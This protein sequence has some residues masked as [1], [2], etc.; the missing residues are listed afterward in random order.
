[1]KRVLVQGNAGL[2][3]NKMT[4]PNIVTNDWVQNGSVDYKVR[5]H[6][7]TPDNTIEI[8][9]TPTLIWT[10][11]GD[12][13]YVLQ[14]AIPT[15]DDLDSILLLNFNG[16]DN[17]LNTYDGSLNYH[18]ITSDGTCRL[19]T[20]QK[21]F[22][23]SS[24][25]FA[26]DG[27]FIVDNY[28]YQTDFG[29]LTGDF[30]WDF[31]IYKTNAS[32]TGANAVILGFRSGAGITSSIIVD[33]AIVVSI[34]DVN[35]YNSGYINLVP[36]GQWSHIVVVRVSGILYVF[37]NELQL[38]SVA[39]V[40]SL[41]ASYCTIGKSIGGTTVNAAAGIYIDT[42]R[43]LKGSAVASSV[44]NPL[45]NYIAPIIITPPATEYSETVYTE[46]WAATSGGILTEADG[47]QIRTF[48]SDGT[49]IVGTTTNFEYLVVG[50]GGGGGTNGRGGGGGGQAL[51]GTVE[52]PPGKYSVKIGTGGPWAGNDTP[53]GQYIKT[54]K[55][56][57]YNIMALPG[58]GGGDPIGGHLYRHGG[59]VN[60]NAEIQNGVI[61]N[62]SGV[63]T[64]YGGGGAGGDQTGAGGLGGGGLHNQ[65]GAA[66]TGGGGGGGDS[67][68]PGTVGGSGIVIIR[69]VI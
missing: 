46:G 1:M 62:I 3:A 57:I 55:T 60:T 13:D 24:A 17:Q 33:Q 25:L 18:T 30:L 34:N 48:T 12:Y 47:K 44:Y 51:T 59:R 56:Y 21:K 68:N 63:E 54:G 45:R 64:Y 26:G 53:E 31:H 7:A 10:R 27:G 16:S 38:A 37:L 66:N 36:T 39:S 32:S 28:A 61:S 15:Q 2:S 8:P 23:T 49:L 9:A 40:Q 20:A 14:D 11:I 65:N 42:V 41:A 4:V 19:S 35:V 43:I 58:Y 52:I 5:N 22:G 50:A 67:G 29:F 6:S 69:Y